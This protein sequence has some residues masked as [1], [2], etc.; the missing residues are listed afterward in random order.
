MISSSIAS[1]IGGLS[2]FIEIILSA[3]V[4]IFLLQNYNH[5]IRENLM[6]VANGQ[7]SQEEFMKQNIFVAVGAMLLIVPGFFTDMIG[8]LL[9]FQFFALMIARRVFKKNKTNFTHSNSFNQN[10]FKNNKGDDDVIDVEIIDDKHIID[11]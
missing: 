9:Q 2:T 11:K 4:G 10:N 8:I 6:S 1:S 3:V 7:I 5:A